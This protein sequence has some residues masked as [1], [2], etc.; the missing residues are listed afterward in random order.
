M[1]H[2]AHCDTTR[3]L[4]EWHKGGAHSECKF[5]VSER[6]AKYRAINRDAL[7]A[8]S[9]EYR[10]HNL[11]RISAHAKEWRKMNKESLRIKDAAKYERNKKAATARMAEWRKANPHIV[12]AYAQK[13]KAARLQAVPPWADLN[14]IKEIYRKARALTKET[15]VQH[16]VDHI[17]PLQSSVVCGLHCEANLRII[18]W[19]ENIK[20]HNRLVPELLEATA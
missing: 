6:N 5:C 10:K 16:H 12:N 3:P 11:E 18:P 7:S 9:A 15:G 4:S 1:K 19:I 17:A 13:H 2:C 8:A 14:A 20:K